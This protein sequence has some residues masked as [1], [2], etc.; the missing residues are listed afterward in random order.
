MECKDRFPKN[1]LVKFI[2][3]SL[4]AHSRG[5]NIKNKTIDEICDEDLYGS[6]EI[7]P[8]AEYW[9]RNITGTYYELVNM[10]ESYRNNFARL[11]PFLLSAGRVITGNVCMLYPEDLVRVHTDG[12]VFNKDHKDVM[13]HFKSY[14]DLLP[15]KKTTGLIDWQN[16]NNYYNMTLKEKHGK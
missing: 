3:S 10:K 12:I 9:I 11:K 5:F 6:K 16:T 8:K 15:E 14:P 13:T 7:D 4:W 1:K 2:C